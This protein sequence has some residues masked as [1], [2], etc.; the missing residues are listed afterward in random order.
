MT[1][2]SSTSE[3]GVR[4]IGLP[5]DDL[6]DVLGDTEAARDEQ[7]ARA[8]DRVVRG[9][10]ATQLDVPLDLDGVDGFR[11]TVLETLV[12]EVGWG[13]TV[14][15]GELAAMAG[16]PR[17]AR[18]VGQR[19]ARQPAAVRDPVPPGRRGRWQASAA[20]AAAATPSRS[21]ARSSHARASAS[22]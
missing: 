18:A 4:E 7:V 22:P 16:R 6:L 3:R 8:L 11:R 20:T 17:A 21:S 13:E 19:D 10:G 2:P 5:D 1:S 15:Y 14:S 12:R 9:A